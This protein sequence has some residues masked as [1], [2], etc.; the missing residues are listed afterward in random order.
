MDK[1]E[2]LRIAAGLSAEE[3]AAIFGA[4]PAAPGS[5]VVKF[6]ASL[7]RVPEAEIADVVN[8]CRAGIKHAEETGD[9]A[10]ALEHLARVSP[11]VAA[12]AQANSV[13]RGKPITHS[14]VVAVTYLQSEE[15]EAKRRAAK[16]RVPPKATTAKAAGEP[17]EKGGK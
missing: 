9:D 1:A 11:T 10:G 6:S 16:R 7:D 13:R 17:G 3:K 4:A 14:L 8:A 5:Q 15:A 12:A 2:F